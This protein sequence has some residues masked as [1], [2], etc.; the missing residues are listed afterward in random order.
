M[1]S[2]V[3]RRLSVVLGLHAVWRELVLQQI[4][5]GVDEACRLLTCELSP[6]GYR[7][8]LDVSHALTSD[9][10]PIVMRMRYSGSTCGCLLRCDRAGSSHRGKRR[11]RLLFR[12]VVCGG[13]DATGLCAESTLAPYSFD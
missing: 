5:T 4:L 12:S 10:G 13:A 8:M 1:M 11:L 3:E 9:G 2:K 7:G 6:G